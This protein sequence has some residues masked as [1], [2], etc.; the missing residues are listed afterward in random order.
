MT[1]EG[2]GLATHSLRSEYKGRIFAFSFCL[3]QKR[4]EFDSNATEIF[5]I[6][7]YR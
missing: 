7:V 6:A 2:Q 4:N 3:A 1:L 5:L